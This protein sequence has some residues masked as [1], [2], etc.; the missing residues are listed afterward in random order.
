M[1]ATTDSPGSGGTV[2][3]N[4]LWPPPCLSQFMSSGL[5]FSGAASW[6]Q[7]CLCTYVSIHPWA[8]KLGGGSASSQSKEVETMEALR[9]QLLRVIAIIGVLGA[10][11][12]VWGSLLIFVGQACACVSELLNYPWTQKD[13]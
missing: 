6:I 8:C 4:G 7:A 12:F 9:S 3:A 10:F 1:W 5:V 11:E 2:G 13:K